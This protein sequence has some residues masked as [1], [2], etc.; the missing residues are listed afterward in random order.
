MISE[1]WVWDT[2]LIVGVVLGILGT[3]AY[4]R[5]GIRQLATA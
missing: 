1:S 4:I 5:T 3:V 2:M